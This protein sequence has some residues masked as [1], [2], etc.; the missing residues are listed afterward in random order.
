MSYILDALRKADQQ[1]RLGAVPTLTHAQVAP[2]ARQR[3]EMLLIGLMGVILIVSIGMLIVWL[4]PSPSEPAGIAAIA[5][6][7]LASPPRQT[8]PSSVAPA[9]LESKPTRADALAATAP[10]PAL[11]VPVP[12]RKVAVT[13][14]NMKPPVTARSETRKNSSAVVAASRDGAGGALP[15]KSMTSS[16]L[17]S[18]IRKTLPVMSVAV[19]AYSATPGDRLVSING[20]LLREGDTLAP[21]LKLEQITADGMIFTYRGYRFRR[22]AQ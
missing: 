6:N 15:R 18:S 3:S 10:T 19:H 5:A 17:P 7:P 2:V 9:K 12:R 8:L 22:D 13:A 4:R 11:A 16:G 1:R 20:R 21:D 14:P